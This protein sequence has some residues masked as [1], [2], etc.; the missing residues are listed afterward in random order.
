MASLR[1]GV[2]GAT[3]IRLRVLEDNVY[4]SVLSFNMLALHRFNVMQKSFS[5]FTPWREEV[6]NDLL[7]RVT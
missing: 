2:R 7:R 5:F 4:N 6:L 1:L 3:E